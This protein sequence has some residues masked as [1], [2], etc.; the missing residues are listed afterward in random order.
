MF[1]PDGAV[2]LLKILDDSKIAQQLHHGKS[3]SKASLGDGELLIRALT[4]EGHA[5][6][7]LDLDY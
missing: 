6:W 7:C 1:A 3:R 5:D 2:V 4:C